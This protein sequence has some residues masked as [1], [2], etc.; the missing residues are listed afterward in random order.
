MKTSE[1]RQKKE[2]ELEKILQEK[3]ENLGNLIFDLAGGK[4]K[5][6]KQIRETKKD[7]AKI[8]TLQ[9]ELKRGAG[10]ADKK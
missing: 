4:V 1:L 2:S 8:M 3:K 10:D 6:I 7:I 5:N 9:S